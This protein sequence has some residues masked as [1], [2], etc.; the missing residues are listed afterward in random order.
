MFRLKLPPRRLK[1]RAA[2]LYLLTHRRI[3]S[4]WWTKRPV[5][6]PATTET[7]K[8]SSKPKEIPGSPFYRRITSSTATTSRSGRSTSNCTPRASRRKRE[9]STLC[10]L[11][12][13]RPSRQLFQ[14]TVAKLRNVVLKSTTNRSKRSAGKRRLS[15]STTSKLP[16]LVNI[17]INI[18]T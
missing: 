17:N 16:N 11:R 9:K 18:N 10:S 7:W 4:C 3:S 12:R 13:R 2:T 8:P 14:T 15:S 1:R 6:F 5:T